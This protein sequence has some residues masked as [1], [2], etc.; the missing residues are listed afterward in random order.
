MCRGVD[1]VTGERVES[2]PELDLQAAAWPR[3]FPRPFLLLLLAERPAHGYELLEQLSSLGAPPLD[4]G[5]LYRAL[6]GMERS[7]LVVSRWEVS[8]V[9]P[10][11]RTY[12]LTEVGRS[13]LHRWATALGEA[14]QVMG[15]YLDRHA[16]LTEERRGTS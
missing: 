10:P 6:R 1:N 8:R 2:P 4:A 3:G 9:G 15:T 14:R 12:E 5:T 7:R 13:E 16:A 11:R